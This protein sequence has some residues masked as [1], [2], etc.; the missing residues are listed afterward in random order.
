MDDIFNIEDILAPDLKE[1]FAIKITNTDNAI[2]DQLHIGYLK[3][4]QLE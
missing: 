1:K 4:E 3:L 2:E